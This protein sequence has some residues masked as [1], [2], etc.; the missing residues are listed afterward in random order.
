ME[1]SRQLAV[2]AHGEID[3]CYIDFIYTYKHSIHQECSMGRKVLVTTNGPNDASFAVGYIEDS[4]TET[5][6]DQ[7]G[8]DA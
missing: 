7:A 3:T 1:V 8:M 5:I 4:I 6:L 2:Q